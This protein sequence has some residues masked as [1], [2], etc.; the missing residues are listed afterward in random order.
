MDKKII[1]RNLSIKRVLFKSHV[2]VNID[3]VIRNLLK[4]RDASIFL[5][6]SV[7]G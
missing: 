4:F 2:L 6:I 7:L 5:T 1:L 3:G